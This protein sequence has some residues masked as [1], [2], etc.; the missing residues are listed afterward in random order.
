MNY[1]IFTT[2]CCKS[3]VYPPLHAHLVVATI[4]SCFKRFSNIQIQMRS[5]FAME[6]SH[7]T[8]SK[9]KNST[10]ITRIFKLS[11]VCV[12]YIYTKSESKIY[13]KSIFYCLDISI[14]TCIMILGTRMTRKYG[15]TWDRIFRKVCFTNRY[16]Y[17]NS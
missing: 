1:Q 15:I 9:A 16:C 8:F 10:K 11:W 7:N 3:S 6:N 14:R 12:Q 17:Q 5:I 13:I 4:F 2:E